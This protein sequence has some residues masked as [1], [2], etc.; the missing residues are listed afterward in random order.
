MPWPTDA[1]GGPVL[2]WGVRRTMRGYLLRG[3]QIAYCFWLLVQAVSYFGALRS[4]SRNVDPWDPW[5]G[6]RTGPSLRREQEDQIQQFFH[7]YR[8][9]L[10]KFQLVL[11]IA[12]TPALTASS[13][14]HEKERGT[15]LAIFCTQLTSWQILVGTLLGRLFLLLPLILTTVPALV[16]IVTW[17]E[18]GLTPVLLALAQQVI[19]ALALGAAGMLFGIWIR[20]AT[21]AVLACYFCLGMAYLLIEGIAAVVPFA[22][23]LLLPWGNLDRLLS[24]RPPLEFVAHLLVW[25][26]LAYVCLRI[27]CSRLRPVCVEQQ[28]K[29]PPRRIWAFRPAVGDNPIRWRECYVIGLAPMPIFQIVPRWLAVLCVF[30]IAMALNALIGCNFSSDFGQGFRNLDPGQVIAGVHPRVYDFNE[31]AA[32]MGLV[33]ILLGSLILGIRCGTSVA[34]EKRRNTWDDLL[35]T[36]QSF[37]EITN[38]KMWGILQATVPYIIAYALPVF[39]VAGITGKGAFV[40]AL[41]WILLPTAIVFAAALMGIDMIQ[42]PR[43]MDETREDGAFWFEKAEARRRAASIQRLESTDA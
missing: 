4:A 11:I 19:V 20:K 23:L 6:L 27:G 14:G 24:E 33:Y 30:G 43:H 36:A 8:E 25:V 42:V 12:I 35:L 18:Q 38:G 31:A 7:D 10:L 1:L 34:E 22:T 15:L 32:I 40:S 5:M 37:R 26:V 28:D 13:L 41:V 39:V 3:F 16:F 9:T 17:T 21:D 29:K 2:A